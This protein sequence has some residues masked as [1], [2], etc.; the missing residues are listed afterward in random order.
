MGGIISIITTI[1]TIYVIYLI[2]DWF[3]NGG[4]K[5]SIPGYTL[6]DGLFKSTREDPMNE[7]PDIYLGAN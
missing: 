5:R 1:I 4:W 7:P 3:F 2:W 6:I